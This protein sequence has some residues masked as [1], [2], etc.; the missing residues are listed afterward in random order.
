[1]FWRLLKPGR[2]DPLLDQAL[3]VFLHLNPNLLGKELRETV[4]L[5]KLAVVEAGAPRTDVADDYPMAIAPRTKP[6]R[7]RGADENDRGATAT[8]RE[9]SRAAI[10]TQ[11]QIHASE[12]ADEFR[13][14]ERIENGIGMRRQRGAVAIGI[15]DEQEMK[16]EMPPEVL[17]DLRKVRLRPAAHVD[18]RAGMQT[19][20][21]LGDRGEQA[22]DEL[23][24][25][26]LA[27][28]TRPGIG[29]LGQ[30]QSANEIVPIFDLVLHRP[31]STHAVREKNAAS[32]RRE[33]VATAGSD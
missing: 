2:N 23:G 11:Q 29:R 18:A 13:N 7:F 33:T 17:D 8:R 26:G 24:V 10:V 21:R 4:R 22:F 20:D 19:D 5:G 30:L 16:I 27:R 15:G 6:D 25:I 12:D 31:G 28:K 1:M 9:V 32:S 14:A 3:D